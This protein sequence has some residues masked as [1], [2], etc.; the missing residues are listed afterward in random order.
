MSTILDAIDMSDDMMRMVS[1]WQIRNVVGR[2]ARAMDRRN[3]DLARECFHDGA[4]THYGDFNGA[5]GGFVPWVL[6]YLETYSCTM[7]FM[8][9]TIVDWIT[10]HDDVAM[11]E[12]YAVALHE[13]ENGQPGRSW[14]G[15]IRYVDRFER[16]AGTAGAN[17][18]WRITERSVIGDWLRID[19]SEYHRRFPTEML[20][21]QPG[22][23]D[24]FFNL[25]SKVGA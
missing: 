3:G 9:A 24:P 12:T 21:G 20:T 11:A 22:P 1:E 19:P 5:V 6:G 23:R 2:Y 4:L 15:G 10:S 14:I 17:P 13:V 16:K 25:L 18:E 8:G 7:H